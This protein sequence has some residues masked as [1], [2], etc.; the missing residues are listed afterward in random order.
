VS[1]AGD[2]RAGTDAQESARASRAGDGPPGAHWQHSELVELFLDNRQA[3]L[4]LIDVQEE[5]VRRAFD[6]HQHELTRFLDVGS[7]NGAVSELLLTGAPDRE[8]VLVDFSEPMLA[9][10]NS[11]L[12][13][14]GRWQGVRGDLADP[15]W[16][17]ELPAGLFSGA[18][19]S[20]AIHH[21]PAERKRSLYAEICELLEPGAMF[22][23]MDYTA[24]AGPL[25]GLWDE[26]ILDNHVRVECTHGGTR[27]KEE[28]AREITSDSDA[29]RPDT[30]EHQLQWLREAG[31]VDVETHFKWAEAAIFGGVRP[32]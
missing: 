18:V 6:Q 27:S 10:A 17:A 7:G 2:T 24:I 22:V 15:A 8:A 26:R 9:R 12:A 23:N 3:L 30:V 4:P 29:D 32:S 5:I 13:G 11:R 14:C 25:R 1:A 19:S 31:F 21:L 16:R 28:I 20:L